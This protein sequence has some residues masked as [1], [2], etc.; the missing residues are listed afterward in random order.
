MEAE[1]KQ[2]EVEQKTAEQLQ[3]LQ[4]LYPYYMGLQVCA[5]RFSEFKNAR[6][7]LK[8]V[9]KNKEAGLPRE[10]VERIWNAT[11]EKFKQLEA[12]LKVAGAPNSTRYVSKTANTLRVSFCLCPAW[13]DHPGCTT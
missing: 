6:V 11:A 7:G 9:L 1:N 10:Q 3:H 12:V 8:N 13:V 2:R 5:E 4:T